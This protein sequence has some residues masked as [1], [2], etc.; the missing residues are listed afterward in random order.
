[1]ARRNLWIALILGL[2]A[3]L[4]NAQTRYPEIEYVA[5]DQSVWTIHVD[6]QGEP[7]NPL[8]RLADKLFAKA[9]I[10]WHAKSYPASRMFKYLQSG[11]AQFSIL[12]KSPALQEC[13][14][15]SRRSVAVAEIR[16]YSTNDKP[17]IKSREDLAGRS[18][19]TVHGYSYG[20]LLGYI[21]DPKNGI[22]NN[23]AQSHQAA[24]L[25]LER[26]RADYLIDYAGPAA[27]VVAVKPL[28][29]LRSDILVRQEVFLVLSKSYPD[30]ERVMERL[31]VILETLEQPKDIP[32]K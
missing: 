26:G 25:M 29:Y 17:V 12:V 8:Y 10:P 24:F 18:V 13:C 3:G 11:T 15:F 23:V 21:T 9:G 20:G 14:L 7:L 32:R 30:A 28:P 1:M 5:P 27:E 16:A 31:E 6:E 19:I 4:S 2:W 22:A